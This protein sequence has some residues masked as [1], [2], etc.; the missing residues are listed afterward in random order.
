MPASSVS[1]FTAKIISTTVLPNEQVIYRLELEAQ[2]EKLLPLQYIKIDAAEG[3][4]FALTNNPG[5][6]DVL[7]D[8]AAA[9]QKSA[10]DSTKITFTSSSFN[11]ESILS[12]DIIVGDVAAFADLICIASWLKRVANQHSNPIFVFQLSVPMPVALRP[13]E[14]YL[15][16]FPSYV[17]AA[18]PLLE[19]WGFASRV[20]ADVPLPGCF[21]GELHELLEA[22]FE[23]VKG[24]PAVPVVRA[25]G[26]NDLQEKV[27]SVFN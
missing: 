16:Q 19:D 10:G 1:E 18:I 26:A 15:P 27:R 8:D 5:Q 13:S 2:P 3:K 21:H 7:F 20:V 24:R 12:A 9:I 22:W 11:A 25:L 6:I 17:T 4:L 23:T 14:F